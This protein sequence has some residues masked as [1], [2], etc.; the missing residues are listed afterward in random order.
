MIEALSGAE[1]LVVRPVITSS[2]EGVIKGDNPNFSFVYKTGRGDTMARMME[3]DTLANFRTGT[4]YC[5]FIATDK[6][7]GL[8]AS[9][10]FTFKATSTVYEGYMVLCN[11]GSDE[12]VRL[13]MISRISADRIVTAHDVMTLLGLP[14]VHHA[15]RI[16]Y[17]VTNYSGTGTV[18][19]LLSKEGGFLL[20]QTTFSTDESYEIR[21]FHFIT[22][23][24]ATEHIVY[25]LPLVG[26]GDVNGPK[27]TFAVSDAGNAYAQFFGSAGAG[28]ESPINTPALLDDPT[29]R[30]APFVGLSMVRPGNGNTA[31]F[32]DIDNKRFVG[33]S[34]GTTD[35]AR[36]VMTPLVDPPG[37]LFSYQTGMDLLHMEGT[38][39]SGGLVYTLLKDA[40]GKRV[41]YGINMSGNGFA[42]EV[43]YENLNA[44]DLD[45][46]TAYAFHSQYPF[47]FY[48]AGNKVYLHNLGTN[49]TYPLAAVDLGATE[50]VTLLKFNLY[51]QISL[52]NLSDQSDEFMARQFELIVG[53]Y[54]NAAPDVNGGKLGFYP[55]NGATNSV[56][57]RIE[58]TGFARIADVVYRER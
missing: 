17:N 6:R 39:Y 23:P 19:Y 2:T 26:T 57:K 3:L 34:Y 40:T 9:A 25:Y 28:F 41:V 45:Q 24:P 33:W 12:R 27:A 36:K 18:I 14:E 30:V 35:A 16:G 49:A 55:V 50:E 21:M 15:T 4:Y 44:P 54:D 31:L 7:T 32:Y 37:A 5:W 42:Q 20:N 53:S 13:D 47:M 52:G 1:R 10:Q 22:P 29:Y 51:A 58:Y 38:R 43:K 56:S 8:A 46:A 11:E 48:A